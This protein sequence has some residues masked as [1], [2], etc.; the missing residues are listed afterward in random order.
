MDLW[1]LDLLTDSEVRSRLEQRG[2]DR[3]SAQHLARYRNVNPEVAAI[4]LETLSGR[5]GGHA[6]EA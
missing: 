5:V 2:V 3:T 4:V 1:E 6:K